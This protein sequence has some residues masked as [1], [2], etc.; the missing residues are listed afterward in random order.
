MDT[1]AAI[2]V[3]DAAV[4]DAAA[5]AEALARM[6]NTLAVVTAGRPGSMTADHAVDLSDQ[7]GVAGLLAEGARRSWALGGR[8]LWRVSNPEDARAK[9]FYHGLAATRDLRLCRVVIDADLA[10][11]AG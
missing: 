11:L 1:P 9:A 5:D 7:P 8:F 3:R 4:A 2:A 10:A 6:M